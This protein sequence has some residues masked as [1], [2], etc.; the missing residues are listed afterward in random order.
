M[1]RLLYQFKKLIEAA[2]VPSIRSHDLRHT[3]ATLLSQGVHPKIAQER[4][5]H[6]NVS[7]TLD[8]YSDVTPDMSEQA[9]DILNA[10]LS[11][12]V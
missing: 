2:E 6:A 4:L 8:C 12:T 3:C 11:G 5:G 1:S 7:M 9:A 10:A